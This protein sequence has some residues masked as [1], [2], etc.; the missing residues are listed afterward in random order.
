MEWISVKDKL[1]EGGKVLVCFQE[2]FFGS[3]T[4]E[5]DVGFY[6][7][8]DSCWWLWNGERKIFR[9]TH[10]MPIPELPESEE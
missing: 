4:S 1:P 9:V 10:W 6:D 5:V 7:N 3:M 8:K 2:P